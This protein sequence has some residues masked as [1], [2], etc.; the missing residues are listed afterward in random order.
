MPILTVRADPR[1]GTKEE[2]LGNFPLILLFTTC[3]LCALFLLWRRASALRT[4]FAHQLQTWNQGEGRIR[5]ST[6][7]G[8]A[9]H[10]FLD[11]DYDDDNERVG[12]SEPLAI[13]AERLRRAAPP[14]EPGTGPVAQPTVLFEA[15]AD[16]DTQEP[17]PLP[18]KH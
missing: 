4:V 16:A 17:P 18:P 13:T 11:D 8:P 7:D 15:D 2:P 12:D 3:T 10:E 9:A 1:Q 14:S 5:L 6:D